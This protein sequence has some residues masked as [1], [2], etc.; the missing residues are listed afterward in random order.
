MAFNMEPPVRLGVTQIVAT[1][2]GSA[3]T[4]NAFAT[5]TSVVRVLATV[6][7]HVVFGASPNTATVNDALVGAHYPEYFIVNGGWKAA[8]VVDAS[9]GRVS[10]TEVSR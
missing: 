6:D 2:T 1:S 7:T 3:E 8:A 4:T 10:F 5:A 9:S